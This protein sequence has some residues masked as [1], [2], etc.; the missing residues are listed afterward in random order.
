MVH[1]STIH[2]LFCIYPF[3]ISTLFGILT[4]KCSKILYIIVDN[5]KYIMSS[6]V[7]L[8]N[9][10]VHYKYSDVD[11]VLVVKCKYSTDLTVHVLVTHLSSKTCTGTSFLHVT[12]LHDSTSPVHISM[13]MWT[14][15]TAIHLQTMQNFF[16]KNLIK[17]R[18]T[19][20]KKP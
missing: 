7:V 16:K 11:N 9:I 17:Q 8:L 12:L 14:I 5:G 10:L 4:K 15:A 18:F 13:M 2:L 1:I 20:K 19:Q 6:L 3:Y